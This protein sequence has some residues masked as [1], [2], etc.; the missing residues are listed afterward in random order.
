MHQDFAGETIVFEG[1]VLPGEGVPCVCSWPGKSTLAFTIASQPKKG[2]RVPAG[3]RPSMGNRS[4]G[5]ADGGH[6]GSETSRKR[7]T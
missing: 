6:G 2:W 4:L 3:V 5:G 7:S 1:R